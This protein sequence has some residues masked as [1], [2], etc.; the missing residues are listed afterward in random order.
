MTLLV[1]ILAARM[2]CAGCLLAIAQ[3]AFVK[4]GGFTDMGPLSR[5]STVNMT[6]WGIKKGTNNWGF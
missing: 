4:P 5:G 3:R 2:V 6:A 1:G